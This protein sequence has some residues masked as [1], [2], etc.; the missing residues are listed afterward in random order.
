V[1]RESADRGGAGFR[2][3][4][5]RTA[6]GF[7]NVRWN[8]TKNRIEFTRS[9][10]KKSLLTDAQYKDEDSVQFSTCAGSSPA[11]FYSY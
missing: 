5:P 8:Q 7:Y 6:R 2:G 4:G 1:E 10:T 9:R 3:D 11:E